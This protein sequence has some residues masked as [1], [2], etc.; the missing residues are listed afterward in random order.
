MGGGA[1]LTPSLKKVQTW[2]L[3]WHVQNKSEPSLVCTQKH[4]EWKC[5]SFPGVKSITKSVFFLFSFC[6]NSFS[7]P[8][9]LCLGY[10]WVYYRR[11]SSGSQKSKKWKVANSVPMSP[12]MLLWSHMSTG[13]HGNLRTTQRL[14]PSFYVVF[15]KKPFTPYLPKLLGWLPSRETLAV[16][17]LWVPLCTPGRRHA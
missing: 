9:C 7:G 6:E 4:V 11:G 10:P 3:S 2:F 14:D 8:L 16:V 5:P 1:F 12:P 13:T 17:A 15:A